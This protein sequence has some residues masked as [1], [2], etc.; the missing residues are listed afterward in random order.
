MPDPCAHVGFGFLAARLVAFITPWQLCTPQSPAEALGIHGLLVVG[1]NLPDLLDKPLFLMKLTRGTRTHGHTLLPLLLATLSSAA[2]FATA[3]VAVG[4][5]WPSIARVVFVAVASHLMADQFFGYVPLLWPLPGWG[6][7]TQSIEKACYRKQ[8][9]R[10]KP[11][12][13]LA[14]IVYVSL[15]TGLPQLVGGWKVYVALLVVGVLTLQLITGVVK[16]VARRQTKYDCD[17]HAKCK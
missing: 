3:P 11:V 6:F 13:D 12:L 2:F 10:W 8:A 1:S 15:D 7:R 9:K 4:C 5:D 17:N 16:G 14:A